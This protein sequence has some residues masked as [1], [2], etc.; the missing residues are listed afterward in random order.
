M[1]E[2]FKVAVLKTAVLVAPWV[3]IPLFPLGNQN[4]NAQLEIL[5]R[6]A[7]MYFKLKKTWTKHPLKIG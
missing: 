2:W 6:I 3:R 7:S 5:T 1:T 4:I